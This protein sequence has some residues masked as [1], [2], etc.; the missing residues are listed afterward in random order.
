METWVD[1]KGYEHKYQVSNMGRVRALDYRMTGLSK[2]INIRD[3]NDYAEVALWKNSSRKLY[4]VHRLV[5][6]AFI[7]NPNNLSQVNHKDENKKN[8]QVDNLEW[9]SQAYNN[10]YGTRLERIK[11]SLNTAG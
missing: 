4:R 6:E 7:P 10:M 8:N 3:N 9:C 5:A 1:I 11:Q 2:L